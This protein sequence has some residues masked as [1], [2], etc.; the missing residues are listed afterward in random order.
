MKNYNNDY[1]SEFEQE[2]ELEYESESLNNESENNE[3]EFE[4]N[5]YELSNESNGELEYSSEF[6]N[7]ESESENYEFENNSETNFESRFYE[8]FTSNFESELEYENSFNEIM[9]EME[10]EYFWGAIKRGI[11]K[12]G[13]I[14]APFAKNLISSFPMGGKIFDLLKTLTSDPRSFLRNAIKQFGPM[15]LNAIVPGSGAALGA[16]MNR[17]VANTN[18]ARQAARDT[19]AL[20][21]QAY[22]N[23]ASGMAQLP[24]TSNANAFRNNL[25]TLAQNSFNQAK[26]TMRKKGKHKLVGRKI[27]AING[28]LYKV[29]TSVYRVR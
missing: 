27:I 16:I 24:P 13:K 8:L 1:L 10:Q 29:V 9:H 11:S 17:E 3:F 15:A 12:I 6:E 2:F 7:N 14:V 22:T 4:N 21:K 25:Q 23:L 18:Q 26:T 20:A 5:E 28:G 19:V